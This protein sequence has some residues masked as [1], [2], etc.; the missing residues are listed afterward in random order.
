MKGSEASE[1]EMP[2][3]EENEKF[4]A[5]LRGG[6]PVEK[7]RNYALEL[8]KTGVKRKPI[9]DMFL[10]FNLVLQDSNRERN[11]AVL[12]DVM[13]M[14]TDSFAPDNPNNMNLPE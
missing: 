3:A 1:G 2:M 4:E 8:S 14:I 13:D 5:A 7:L 12:G 11:E 9:Y 6:N 10:K